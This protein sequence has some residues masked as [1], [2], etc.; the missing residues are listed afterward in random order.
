MIW[1]WTVAKTNPITE[2][3]A[4]PGLR[5]IS[6]GESPEQ[7]VKKEGL[8]YCEACVKAEKRREQWENEEKDWKDT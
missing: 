4:V 7:L 1:P 5:C 2:I 6:C 3:K 8:Y